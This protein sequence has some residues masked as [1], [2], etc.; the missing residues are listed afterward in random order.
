VGRPQDQASEHRPGRL[1]PRRRAHG[2]VGNGSSKAFHGDR[3][4]FSSEAGMITGW[5][6]GSAATTEATT[7]GA[8]YKG[9]AIAGHRL[10]ATD[11]H[12]GKVDAFDSGFHPV[13]H[14]GFRDRRLPRGYAPFGIQRLGRRIYVTYAK[15][16]A[17][18]EDDVAGA[19]NG[20]VDVY[21]TGGKL[22]DRLIRRGALN[23]PWGLVQTASAGSRTTC[24]WAT[25]VTAPSTPTAPVAGSSAGCAP[26]TAA[27]SSSPACGG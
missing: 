14:P 16:D 2:Q 13:K 10:Y 12:N 18:R 19:G 26:S 9:L 11:F 1:D 27:R 8:I 21:T 4:I 25:S 3:F 17:D 5:S 20:F 22:V 23:S 15:Q 6:S 24:S 7:P